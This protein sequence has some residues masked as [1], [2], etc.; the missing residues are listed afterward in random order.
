MDYFISKSFIF[1]TA[2]SFA[3]FYYFLCLLNSLFNV[4]NVH[5]LKQFICLFNLQ[6]STGLHSKHFNFKCYVIDI[7]V[8]GISENKGHSYRKPDT[9]Y[10]PLIAF[11]NSVF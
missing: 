9:K 7:C 5:M 11:F 8:K 6:I 1:A 2:I 3:L 4:L 10:F